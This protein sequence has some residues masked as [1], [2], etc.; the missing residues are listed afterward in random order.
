MKLA[1]EEETDSMAYIMCSKKSISP[2]QI[3]E[4]NQSIKVIKANGTYKGILEKYKLG[5]N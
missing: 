3:A 1:S 4:F 2:D 5:S